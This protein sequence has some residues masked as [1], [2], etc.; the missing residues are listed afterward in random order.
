MFANLVPVP[1]VPP[2]TVLDIEL[3]YN[4]KKY[5]PGE[6]LTGRVILQTSEPIRARYLKISWEGSTS[7]EFGGMKRQVHF[8]NCVIP[9]IAETGDSVIPSGTHKFRFSFCLPSDAPPSFCGYYGSTTYSIYVKLDRVW[10]WNMET[11]KTFK[12]VPKMCTAAMAPDM[13]VPTKFVMYKNS[14]SIFKDGVFS[15]KLNFQKRSF[16]PGESVEVIVT[17]ENNSSKPI[18]SMQFELIRQSHFHSQH[19]KDFCSLNNC[20]KDCPVPPVYTRNCEKVLNSRVYPCNVPPGETEQVMV[21][22]DLP[23]GIPATFESAMISM[24]YLLGFSLKN[25]SWTNNK[26]DCNARIVIGNE[27]RIGVSGGK[28]APLAPPPYSP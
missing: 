4:S 14:G 6:T 27:E 26:I 10:K 11:Q 5:F 2:T 3:S 1:P 25:G 13:M 12:V 20:L 22:V 28:N 9:W 24:G 19:Q 8:S 17:M 7:C 21:A 18:K 15:I 16:M 23:R